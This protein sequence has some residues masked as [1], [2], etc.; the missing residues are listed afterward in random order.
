VSRGVISAPWSPRIRSLP[1]AWLL[2]RPSALFTERTAQLTIEEVPVSDTSKRIEGAVEQVGG[3]LKRA[4]GNLIGN[5]Q[6]A[7]EGQAKELEGKA[8]QEAAK[9]AERVKGT[10]QEAGGA[11]EK[12]AGKLI[13]NE[14]MEAEGKAKELEGKARQ[15]LNQ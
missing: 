10:V 15:K 7:A 1:P 3:K 9:A 12:G 8:K 14:Q 6:M 4:L 5:E 13:G 11:L 2:L